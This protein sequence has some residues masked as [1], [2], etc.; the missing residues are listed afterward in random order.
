MMIGRLTGGLVVDRLGRSL[1]LAIFGII[2]SVGIFVVVATNFIALPLVGAALWGL[3]NSLGFPMSVAAVSREPRL[4]SSR[5]NVLVVSSNITG[6]AGPPTLGFIGQ[7]LGLFAAFIVPGV[8]VLA[9]LFANSA[10][11]VQASELEH[12]S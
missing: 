7:S 12:S 6:V 11:K 2:T 1:S 8:L 5:V 4:S 9:G 10:T 3:G